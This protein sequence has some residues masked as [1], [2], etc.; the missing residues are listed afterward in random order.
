MIRA[1][2]PTT[3]APGGTSCVTTA[4]APTSASAP[5][6]T[7]GSTVAFAPSRARAPIRGPSSERYAH[8]IADLIG[9]ADQGA[10][11]RLESAAH[12]VRGIDHRVRADQ[13][14]GTERRRGTVR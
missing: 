9:F 11:T 3:T 5:T 14:A 6:T 12:P 1:G 13:Q 4:P 2:L 8:A 7:P 10:V